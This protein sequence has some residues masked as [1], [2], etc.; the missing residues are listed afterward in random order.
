MNSK[1][2]DVPK[3]QGLEQETLIMPDPL[4]SGYMAVSKYFFK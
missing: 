1:T 2:F 3:V 4:M